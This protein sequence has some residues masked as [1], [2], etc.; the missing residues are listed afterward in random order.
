MTS[1]AGGAQLEPVTPLG[2]PTAHRL[3]QGPRPAA[4]RVALG[5]H[6]RHCAA[7]AALALVPGAADTPPVC[8]A[9]ILLGACSHSLLLSVTGRDAQSFDEER[10][11]TCVRSNTRQIRVQGCRCQ[12]ACVAA[13]VC[14]CQL[15]TGTPNPLMRREP[16]LACAAT[17]GKLR[18]RVAGV[19]LPVYQPHHLHKA[20]HSH[21]PGT[22]NALQ[23]GLDATLK[24]GPTCSRQADS[25]P[26]YQPRHPHPP[27]TAYDLQRTGCHL[28]KRESDMQTEA[29]PAPSLCR[30]ARQHSRVDMSPAMPGCR[31]G[32]WGICSPCWLACASRAVASTCSRHQK[33]LSHA[34]RILPGSEHG[35]RHCTPCMGQA[36]NTESC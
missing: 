24:R 18:F 7:D 14:C 3:Q 17:R 2:G 5:R 33:A 4:V 36:Q 23:L 16:V 19:S 27:G 34:E 35:W 31:E 6:G 11:I 1:P 21:P 25:L 15:L 32:M 20:H 30:E 13:T 28:G 12:S 9:L 22:A 8:L 10:T 29:E 26:V